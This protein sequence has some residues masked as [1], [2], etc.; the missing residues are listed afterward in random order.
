MGM[1]DAGDGLKTR[2]AT[3]TS[4]NQIFSPSEIPDSINAF[5]CA[6]ILPGKSD[7]DP[8]LS[9]AANVD[10][11]LRILI[12]LGKPDQ[13]SALNTI[14]EYADPTGTNS[15]RAA[16]HADMT[17]GGNAD[18][19]QVINNSGAGY[20]VWGGI[21]YLSTEFEIKVYV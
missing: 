18:T 15:V 5:P 8:T 16:I 6:I 13:P 11:A 7:Y 10:V 19:C 20:T 21:I 1:Q 12:L 14:I 9:E 4:L 2:L 3:I 17:L